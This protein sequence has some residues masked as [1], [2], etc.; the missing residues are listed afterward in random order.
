MSL[1]F[2]PTLSQRKIFTRSSSPLQFKSEFTLKADD[3]QVIQYHNADYHKMAN[4][5]NL[6]AIVVSILCLILLVIGF[7]SFCVDGRNSRQMLI[8]L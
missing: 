7:V 6:L 1:I 4:Q 8:A 2:D 3:N 5:I